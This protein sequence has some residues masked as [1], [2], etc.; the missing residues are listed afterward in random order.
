MAA[1]TDCRGTESAASPA[2]VVVVRGGRP[3]SGKDRSR[4][5]RRRLRQEDGR[6]GKPA[7]PPAEILR[8]RQRLR[9]R[10]SC[11]HVRGQQD[12]A[13]RCAAS[14]GGCS[15]H[16][17]GSSPSRTRL[18][19]RLSHT[20][21][22][23][24]SSPNNNSDAIVISRSFIQPPF[25]C[26]S[27]RDILPC[28]PYPVQE[29]TEQPLLIIIITRVPPDGCRLLVVGYSNGNRRVFFVSAPGFSQISSSPSSSSSCACV[30]DVMKNGR[31]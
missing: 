13:A 28:H 7:D 9:F 15:L 22:V 27:S 3:E 31:E 4:R 17:S 24:M 30:C 29:Q 14:T 2:V 20:T 23:R 5:Q 11:S 18:S 19:H 25:F 21:H 8:T 16:R 6:T 1:G 26:A 12:Y 10:N